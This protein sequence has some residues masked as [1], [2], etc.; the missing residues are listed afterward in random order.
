MR[1]I[2]SKIEVWAFLRRESPVAANS[3]KNGRS[4]REPADVLTYY[5]VRFHI[6]LTNMA[7]SGFAEKGRFYRQYQAMNLLCQNDALSCALTA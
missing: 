4:G 5:R 7:V 1:L 6:V 2:L 3:V